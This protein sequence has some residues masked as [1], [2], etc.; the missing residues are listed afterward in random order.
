MSEKEEKTTLF[1]FRKAK[2]LTQL[3]IANEIGINVKT[4]ARYETEPFSAPVSTILKLA[5]FYEISVES[6]FK[7]PESENSY[8]IRIIQEVKK[9]NIEDSKFLY[10]YIVFMKEHRY[11]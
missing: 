11:F 4:Y 6:L 2:G 8:H 9:L 3:D 10:D 7:M 5:K 1:K